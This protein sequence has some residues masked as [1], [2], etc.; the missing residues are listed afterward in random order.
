MDSLTT[1][2]P[3]IN[4]ASHSIINPPL[5]ERSITSPGTNSTEEISI[6]N[7]C[8]PKNK[9]QFLFQPNVCLNFV[10]IT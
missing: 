4:T 7:N 10:I 2:V 5:V 9:K 3:S 6:A 8:L 1:Q